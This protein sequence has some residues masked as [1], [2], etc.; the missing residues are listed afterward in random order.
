MLKNL[1]LEFFPPNLTYLVESMDIGQTDVRKYCSKE[2]PK[3]LIVNT[4][5][6]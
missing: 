1:H 6:E 3:V 5:R 2:I 4:N